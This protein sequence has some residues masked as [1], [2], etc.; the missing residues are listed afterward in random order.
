MKFS[1]LFLS[2][3]SGLLF[4]FQI[5]AQVPEAMKYQAVIR[6]A[7]GAIL[8][9]Q[10]VALRIGISDMPGSG[11]YF[12][13]ESHLTTTNQFGLINIEIGMGSVITGIFSSID[14]SSG[15]YFLVT[16]VDPDNSGSFVMLSETQL[17][18][19]PYAFHAKTAANTFSGDY[20]DL[21]NAPY[22]PA[23]TS[24]LINDVG[25]VTTSNDADS[26]PV[27]EFQTLSINGN[28]LSITDGNTVALPASP[29][30]LSQLTNDMGFV[31]TSND[32]DYD[33]TNE[34]QTISLTSDSVISISGGGSVSIPL[35]MYGSLWSQNGNKIYYNNDYVGIGTVNPGSK[36]EVYS[37]GTN[38]IDT[39]IFSVKNSDG[40][41]V[42]AVYE[43]GVRV[44]VD[45][46]PGAKATGSK[47][48]FAVGGF[49][50]A[51]GLTDDYLWV[52]PD[53]VRVYIDDAN[54]AGGHSGGFSVGS[55]D[56]GLAPQGIMHMSIDN[57]F[58]GHESGRAIN[59]GVYNSFMG[60]QSGRSTSDGDYNTAMGYQSLYANGTGYNNNAIGY[61]ALKS[62]TWGY[63]NV[64]VGTNA[65]RDN[66]SGNSN[67]AIGN[68]ALMNNINAEGGVAIG[69]G[70]LSK[71]TTGWSNTGVGQQALFSNTTG[72]SN[73]AIGRWS[74][75]SNTTGQDNTAVGNMAFFNGSNYTNST[76]IGFQALPTG[77]N[78]VR[79]GNTSVTSLW[80]SGAYAATTASAANMYVNSAGQIMRSTS[81]K[82][83]KTDIT[84]LSID[85]E[86]IYKLRPVSYLSANDGTEHFGLIAEEVAELIP[87]LAEFARE[88]D[89]IPGSKS[90]I[91]IPDA[92][93]YP[94]LSVLLL[95]ELQKHEKRIKEL[96]S[97]LDRYQNLE[98]RIESVEKQIPNK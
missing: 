42:F 37:D 61:Q 83:Y 34:I 29:S 65:L 40:F 91:L 6:D 67:T 17:L 85:T 73:V 72:A 68:E 14:W 54:V 86:A 70:A 31:T 52:T 84:D 96:E 11:T 23:Y 75:Y 79:L 7:S 81:S 90:D 92:V 66:T 16:E 25:Y 27:N 26:D 8:S 18:S 28:N 63:N 95:K 38:P 62:N 60:Y 24:E 77:S 80:C 69:S 57:Y 71:S 82:R 3:F 33:P 87:Q 39:A 50:Q 78:Q 64:A 2:L 21:V 32:A 97:E 74:M 22:V 9:D 5:M 36:L 30:S 13:Q 49:S 55:F 59:N 98:K 47:G 44:Y 45:D 76:A 10:S 88:S 41:T 19:V 89:V 1:T 12:Y 53:S 58:I 56:A 94:L 20:G 48:G 15:Q 4:S 43:E 51:K 93:Q 35:S 46:N